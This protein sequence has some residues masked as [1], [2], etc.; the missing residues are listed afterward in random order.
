M[1]P[2]GEVNVSQSDEGP[3]ADDKPGTD[4]ADIF[5]QR[6]RRS[7]INQATPVEMAGTNTQYQA[8]QSSGGIEVRVNPRDGLKY[9]RIPPGSFRMGSSAGDNE[10]Q[11]DEQPSHEVTITRAFWLGT[12]EV[13]Q[14]A[15][16]ALMQ[17]N[18]SLRKGPNHPVEYVS[19]KTAS[20]YCSAAGLRLPTEAEWEYAARAGTEQA[21]YGVPAQIA[22]FDNGAGGNVHDV[23]L[24]QPNRWGLYDMLG[25]VAEYVSDWYGSY[26]S[27]LATDPTGPPTG[28]QHLVRGGEGYYSPLSRIRVSARDPTP[29]G[30][31]T[32][33]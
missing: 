28:K 29:N 21:Y 17:S 15:Y 14:A 18:P 6:P 24:K 30:D 2:L 25:N 20:V 12:T 8:P 1:K 23:G 13:T 19:W 11:P 33:G 22:W 4:W 26:D 32:N 31:A 7:L 16:S 5:R 3:N 10:C 9:V 27:G